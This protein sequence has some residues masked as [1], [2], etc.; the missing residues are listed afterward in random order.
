MSVAVQSRL[1]LDKDTLDAAIEKR[2]RLADFLSKE[3]RRNPTPKIQH[4][5][6][7]WYE[8]FTNQAETLHPIYKLKII[9]QQRY[10]FS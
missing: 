4:T 9:K 10:F 2:E 5:V 7:Q 6:S 3:V 8:L 1:Q